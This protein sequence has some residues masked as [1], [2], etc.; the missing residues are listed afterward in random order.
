MEIASVNVSKLK[1]NAVAGAQGD[2]WRNYTGSGY[3]APLGTY[4]VKEVTAPSG[5]NLPNGNASQGIVFRVYQTDSGK[6][7]VKTYFGTVT[8]NSAFGY[9]DGNYIVNEPVQYGWAR[10]IKIAEDNETPVNGSFE[11]S[12]AGTTYGIY[13]D[14]NGN[15]VYDDGEP[16]IATVVLD[17]DGNME[18]VTYA[19]GFTPK[20]GFQ[21]S[22]DRFELPSGNY[23]AVELKAAKGY[24]LNDENLPFTVEDN[25]T[26]VTEVAAIDPHAYV[27]VSFILD[28]ES[29][30]GNSISGAVFTVYADPKCTKVVGTLT[31]DG[32]GHYVF[33]IEDGILIAPNSALQ[34][35]NGVW[36]YVFDTYLYVK[37]TEGPD[38]I[39]LNGSRQDLTSED[40]NAIIGSK[41]N[42]PISRL[43]DGILNIFLVGQSIAMDMEQSDRNAF[44][45]DHF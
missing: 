1:A 31:D 21:K 34:G 30:L 33:S 36:T 19:E 18:S 23:V 24:Y 10:L 44:L 12:F 29:V 42:Q 14:S 26:K 13:A 41:S 22:N 5:Y 20:F 7:D 11:V 25:S 38:C 15:K 4:V 28:K 32:D 45:H 2:Y 43:G 35:A 6:A 40:S 9:L 37:E 16:L 3:N 8:G 27:R 17:A 39:I